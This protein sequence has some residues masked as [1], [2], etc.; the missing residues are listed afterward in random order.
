MIYGDDD[1]DGGDEDDDDYDKSD[2]GEDD[3]YGF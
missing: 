3:G 1:S 2:C